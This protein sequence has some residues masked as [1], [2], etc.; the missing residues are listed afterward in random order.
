MTIN[1]ILKEEF[2]RKNWIINNIVLRNQCLIFK[3]FP[4]SVLKVIWQN[5]KSNSVTHGKAIPKPD[6]KEQNSDNTQKIAPMNTTK[7]VVIVP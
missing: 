7:K 6:E 1:S 2:K 5:P 4:F 3:Q